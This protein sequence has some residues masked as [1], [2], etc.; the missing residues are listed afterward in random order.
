MDIWQVDREHVHTIW[1]DIK[2][3]IDRTE[4]QDTS[5]SSVY[6]ALTEGYWHLWVAIGDTGIVCAATTSFV[7]YPSGKM[8][9]VETV[10][11]DGMDKWLFALKEIEEWAKLN[12]CIAMDIFGR[13]GWEKVL[14]PLDYN[15][16]AILLRKRLT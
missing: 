2:E 7:F 16:E 6:K 14:A 1:D 11:G 4:D 13:K 9:R 15:F 3:Y 5:T 12:G 10:G 8:C